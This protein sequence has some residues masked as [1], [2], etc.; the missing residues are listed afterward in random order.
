MSPWV[1]PAQASDA[2][3]RGQGK[4]VKIAILDSG[5]EASH[6]ALAAMELADD[7]AIVEEG[8]QLCTIP[9]GGLDVFGHGTAVAGIIHSRAPLATIG[10]F[11]VL[12]GS[13]RSRTA[14]IMEGARAAIEGG[15]QIIN[16]SL[17]SGVREHWDKF[18]YWVDEAYLRGVHIV[19]ACNNQDASRPEWPAHF[20]SVI[21]VN[22]ARH[23]SPTD[24]FYRP[25]SLVEFAAHGVDVEV[26]WSG[27]MYRQMSGS[28]FA[29]PHVTAMLARLLSEIPDLTPL[30]AKLLL[31]KVA[32]P[33]GPGVR[34]S[35]DR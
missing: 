23:A 17:G 3:Q 35:N 9:G 12:S 13:L 6:P 8:R 5:I 11:R 33:C 32:Q 19:A 21:A 4:G 27:G 1:D 24:L 25:G 31:Q 16:C 22:M 30:Q 29:A 14:I 10:S 34:A 28:S 26:A 18:K 7:S 20:T 15:Y 2:I